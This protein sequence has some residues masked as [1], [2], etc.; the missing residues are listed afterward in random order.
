MT[1]TFD[2]GK[3]LI[4]LRHSSSFFISL[5]SPSYMDWLATCDEL[6]YLCPYDK[7]L[8]YA[9]GIPQIPTDLWGAYAVLQS[10]GLKSHYYIGVFKSSILIRRLYKS[11]HLIT[12]ISATQTEVILYALYSLSTK[13]NRP[14][15]SGWSPTKTT[16]AQGHQ[17]SSCLRLYEGWKMSPKDT[18]VSRS[19]FVMV[20][21]RGSED[22]KMLADTSA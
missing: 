19:K 15:K 3:F 13:D 8:N 14:A 11:N 17:A 18:R 6:G 22:T 4:P 7:L 21:W 5:H 2:R 9:I 12:V 16:V 20:W 10:F 1:R